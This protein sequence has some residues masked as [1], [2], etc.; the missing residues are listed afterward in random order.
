MHMCVYRTGVVRL[1]MFAA[2]LSAMGLTVVGLLID[3][4][5]QRRSARGLQQSVNA[6]TLAANTTHE[7]HRKLEARFDR[8]QR[9]VQD[10][11]WRDSMMLTRFDW[12]KPD[13]F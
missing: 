3:A 6:L 11:G 9:M 1:C 12:R 8:L 5:Q 4:V 10:R 13:K 2:I 7:N